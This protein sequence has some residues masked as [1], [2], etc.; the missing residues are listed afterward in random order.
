MSSTCWSRALGAVP[1][2][3]TR[4]TTGQTGERTSSVA[5]RF[6]IPTT[7]VICGAA[8]HWSN[9]STRCTEP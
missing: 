5:A 3:S 4:L 6:M 2:R 7:S 1:V 9:I 8:G